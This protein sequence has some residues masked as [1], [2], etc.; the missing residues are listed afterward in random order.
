MCLCFVCHRL[1]CPVLPV[2]LDCL[3]FVCHRLVCPVLPVSLD[4]LCFVC[5]RLVCPVLP[6]SLDCLFFVAPSVFSNVY[7]NLSKPQPSSN[8]SAIKWS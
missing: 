4:C 5:H 2:S 6:V 3:C 8:I 1:V 7:L